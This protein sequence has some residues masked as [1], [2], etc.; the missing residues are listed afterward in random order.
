PSL[1]QIHE[2]KKLQEIRIQRQLEKIQSLQ[3]IVEDKREILRQAALEYKIMDKYREKKRTEFV[4][5]ANKKEQLEIDEM[6]VLRFEI[7]EK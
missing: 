4:T 3:K 6:A 5:E 7:E 2:F 1:G